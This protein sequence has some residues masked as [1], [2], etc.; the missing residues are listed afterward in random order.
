MSKST[1]VVSNLGVH[2]RN[3]HIL[4]IKNFNVLEGEII[5]IHGKNGTGKST[6][7]KTIYGAIG[8][9]VISQNA[10]ISTKNHTNILK[11][12]EKENENHR[13]VFRYISQDDHFGEINDTVF[14]FIKD[15]IWKFDQ[16]TSINKEQVQQ[17]LDE[18]L[19]VTENKKIKSTIDVNSKLSKLSGG[20][21]RMVRLLPYLR[22][23]KDSVLL[24][25]DE[26]FNNLD[27]SSCLKINNFFNNLH[28]KNPKIA[29]I[30]VS[31]YPLLTFIKKHFFLE[32]KTLVERASPD[33]IF[34]TDE[35]LNYLDI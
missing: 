6:F 30:F 4:D 18:Y 35:N 31:H 33:R 14:N 27:I 21:A 12:N 1:L 22:T 5:Q 17:M 26:P 7:L 34:R 28:R 2:I 23:I 29:M 10:I 11:L 32:N 24:L 8:D 3:K 20:Q 15:H 9:Y 13:S 19:N 25:V 16:T